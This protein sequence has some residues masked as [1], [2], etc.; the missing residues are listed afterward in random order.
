M[1]MGGQGIGCI[2]AEVQGQK[3]P[4]GF[5][6]ENCRVRFIVFNPFQKPGK[7]IAKKGGRA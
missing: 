7:A 3:F 1:G 6:T 5:Y 4:A 2:A